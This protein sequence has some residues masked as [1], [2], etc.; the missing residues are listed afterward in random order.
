MSAPGRRFGCMKTLLVLLVLLLLAG[1]AFVWWATRNQSVAA[2][3]WVDDRFGRS[4]AIERVA[5]AQYG[6]DPRQKLGVWMPAAERADTA[7]KPP[8]VIWIH[9][10]GWQTGDPFEYRFVARAMGEKPYAVAL[11]GY[12]LG[13]DGAYPA[14]L[15]DGAASIRWLVENADRLGYDAERIVLM[16]HSAG[17]YNAVML[18]LDRQWLGREGLGDATID[19]V[20]GLA[21]P[22][23]FYPFEGEGAKIAFGNVADPA[24]TQPIDAVRGDAPPML[25]VTGDADT[26]VDP[27][28][29]SRLADAITAAGGKARAVSLEGVGHAKIVMMFAQPFDRDTRMADAVMPFIEQV[30]A[31]PR[32]PA[33]PPSSPQTS[34]PIQPP[35]R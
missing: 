33:S 7:G 25:L 5:G 18:G 22:Y 23:D 27:V 2:L 10:G 1:G 4:G 35:E 20:V 28:N 30:F 29:S 16:G 31:S 9:G 17:A 26:T 15:Q 32:R 21:G 12:R 11:V 34:A 8:V 13:P 19:G 14:M 3:D 6:T 24:V